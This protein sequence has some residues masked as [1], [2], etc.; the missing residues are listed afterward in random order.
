MLGCSTEESKQALSS[1]GLGFDHSGT[2]P[3]EEELV[4]PVSVSCGVHM[5]GNTLF[6]L[7]ADPS[8]VSGVASELVLT[9]TGL[10]ESPGQDLCGDGIEQE[11]LL[12]VTEP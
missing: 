9:H 3:A 4:A 1:G 6:L 11:W 7:G 12:L 2:F 8:G 5:S 10:G